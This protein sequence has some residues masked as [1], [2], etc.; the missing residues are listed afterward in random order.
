[1]STYARHMT[2]LRA[3]YRECRK[4]L[5]ESRELVSETSKLLERLSANRVDYPRAA[6]VNYSQSDGETSD[7][8][9]AKFVRLVSPN[10][11][12]AKDDG[13]SEKNHG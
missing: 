2:D 9:L 7:F 12:G 1:M 3:A 10:N 8:P 4:M 13:S 11:E 5:A 6:R